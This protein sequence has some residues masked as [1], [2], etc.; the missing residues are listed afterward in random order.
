ME[1]DLLPY[2]E[3]MIDDVKT[4]VE[5]ILN[6]KAEKVTKFVTGTMNHVFKIETDESVVVARI[7]GKQNFPNCEKLIWVDDI[8]RTHD[9]STARI[10]H[11]E[12]GQIPFKHGY[13]LMEF[14]GGKNGRSAIKDGDISFEDYFI[15]FGEL[16][17]R[18]HAIRLTEDGAIK[19]SLFDGGYDWL[20]SVLADCMVKGSF[21][22]IDIIKVKKFIVESLTKYQT[23]FKSVL[24]HCDTGLQNHIYTPSGEI[25]L[26]DWDFAEAGSLFRDLSVLTFDGKEIDVFGPRE[27]VI[28]KIT[29]SFLK[30]YGEIGFNDDE[31]KEI[32][33]AHH[34]ISRVFNLAAC[35]DDK[36]ERTNIKRIAEEIRST[37]NV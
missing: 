7:F 5:K 1:N 9:I 13:M 18:I 29:G 19:L 15:K 37:L 33:N 4:T 11:C 35:G 34:L 27:E 24:C 31:I 20:D 36:A 17:R 30:G 14:V 3:S 10:L 25:V 2:D 28:A 16:M 23:R 12:K 21:S 32:V 22:T 6:C 26:I 8:L